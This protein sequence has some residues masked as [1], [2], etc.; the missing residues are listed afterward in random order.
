[1]AIATQQRFYVI[2]GTLPTDAPS[3]VT[4]QADTELL[5]ALRRGEFCYVLDTRQM[6]K[7]SLMVRTAQRLKEEGFAVAVLDLTAVGQNVTV[8]QW[9]DGLLTALAEQLRLEDEREDFWL[10]NERLG[11]MQR[12]FAAIRQVALPSPRVKGLG[13]RVQD[14]SDDSQPSTLNPQPSSFSLMRLT[15]FVLSPPPPMSSSLPSAS[16]TTAARLTPP[17]NV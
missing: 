8:E 11:P 5:E 7:S 17:T 6:G 12:F 10:D 16:A 14:A 4:R 3:Y 13:F 9:Y 15:P 1:M 2:G